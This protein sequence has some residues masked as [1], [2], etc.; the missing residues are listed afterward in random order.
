MKIVILVMAMIGFLNVSNANLN[1]AGFCETYED[2]EECEQ[3]YYTGP[4]G[5]SYD[6]NGNA[7]DNDRGGSYIDTDSGSDGGYYGL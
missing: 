7:I 1:S 4:D 3:D 5:Q 6:D 2:Y